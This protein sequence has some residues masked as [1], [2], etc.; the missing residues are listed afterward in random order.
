MPPDDAGEEAAM[1]IRIWRFPTLVLTALLAGMTFCH[2]L[3]MPAK[4]QYSAPMY[5]AL[6]RTLYVAFG[7]PNIGVFVEMGAI[8]SSAVLVLLVRRRAGFWPTLIGAG[9]LLMGL[10]TYFAQVEPANAALKMMALE[11]PPE[12][13]KLWRDRWEYGHVLHFLFDFLGFCALTWSVLLPSP[14]VV[15]G[16]SRRLP[17]YD[18]ESARPL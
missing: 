10:L 9:C 17:T 2:V 14:S 5:L 4:L 12:D 18:S 1:L 15:D 3:E 6:H 11:A 8:L 13:W 16:P 7:P